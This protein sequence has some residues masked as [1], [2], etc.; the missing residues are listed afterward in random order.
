MTGQAISG[1]GCLGWKKST[2]CLSSASQRVIKTLKVCGRVLSPVGKPLAFVW[3]HWSQELVPAPLT[4][5][6]PLC[7]GKGAAWD[8]F[9]M[10]LGL[11]LLDSFQVAFSG[12]SY[13]SMVSSGWLGPFL[14]RQCS[15]P[16]NQSVVPCGRPCEPPSPSTASCCA[17]LQLLS[18]SPSSNAI[19]GETSAGSSPE[20]LYGTPSHV[21]TMNRREGCAVP[22]SSKVHAQLCAY[23]IC[24]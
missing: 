18:S 6:L 4:G 9:V 10:G 1:K 16:G 15:F 12:L 23:F 8:G 14:P 2:Q 19:P 5:S 21:Q 13:P 22:V 24:Q 3:G 11:T 7:R 20:G 17:S